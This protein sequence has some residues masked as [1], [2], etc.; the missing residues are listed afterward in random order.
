MPRHPMLAERWNPA[1]FDAWH[2]AS[3]KD[4]VTLREALAP[5]AGKASRGRPCGMP[6]NGP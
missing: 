2:E 5:S 4:N 1:V 6:I 3:L